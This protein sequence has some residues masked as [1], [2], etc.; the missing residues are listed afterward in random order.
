M[1]F[2]NVTVGKCVNSPLSV[3]VHNQVISEAAAMKLEIERALKPVQS[4]TEKVNG[5]LPFA[6]C[7]VFRLNCLTALRTSKSSNFEVW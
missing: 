3:M 6:M 4:E 7:T 2:G 1:M 5:C